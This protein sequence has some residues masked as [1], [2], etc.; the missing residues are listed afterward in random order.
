MEIAMKRHIPKPKHEYNNKSTSQKNDVISRVH[1]D[2]SPNANISVDSL[3]PAKIVRLQRTLG[4]QFML[5]LISRTQQSPL[6]RASLKPIISSTSR[7]K[8]QKR[9]NNIFPKFTK[10]A[11]QNRKTIQRKYDDLPIEGMQEILGEK[12][13]GQF[14]RYNSTGKWSDLAGE[15]LETQ[16]EKDEKFLK[17]YFSQIYERFTDDEGV[18]QRLMEFMKGIEGHQSQIVEQRRILLEKKQQQVEDARETGTIVFQEGLRLV[19]PIH[20]GQVL[21]DKE[22]IPVQ[23]NETLYHLYAGQKFLNTG[24]SSKLFKSAPSKKGNIEIYVSPVQDEALDHK[25]A[26]VG[27]AHH[28]FI[29]GAHHGQQLTAELIPKGSPFKENWSALTYQNNPKDLYDRYSGGWDAH[30]DKLFYSAISPLFEYK[31]RYFENPNEFIM[32][33][34]RQLTGRENLILTEEQYETVARKLATRVQ[35]ANPKGYDDLINEL[36]AS[37]TN[38][39]HAQALGKILLESFPG[40]MM[41]NVGLGPTESMGFFTHDYNV[42]L[43]DPTKNPTP[44][45]LLDTLAF[46][47]NNA[48]RRDELLAGEEDT[49][50]I[51][52]GTQMGYLDM[53]METTATSSIDTLV[54]ALGIDEKY[55]IPSDPVKSISQKDLT[56]EMPSKK[57]LTGQNRRT[58]L[59]YWKMKEWT[60]GQQLEYNRISAHAEG[61]EATGAT[62]GEDSGSKKAVEV[63][64]KIDKSGQAQP[65]LRPL[66]IRM[67]KAYPNAQQYH[68]DGLLPRHFGEFLM[69]GKITKWEGKIAVESSGPQQDI[70]NHLW[71]DFDKVYPS[72]LE[73][74]YERLT[75]TDLG[76]FILTGQIQAMEDQFLLAEYRH[77]RDRM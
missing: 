24:Y 19:E 66:V 46:E 50:D 77:N 51:E 53:L 26:I 5:N 55:L 62:Y 41:P 67:T 1:A 33:S 64:D 11:G 28:R 76:E 6:Q 58:A 45:E 48:L 7:L 71:K 73:A 2:L 59:A 31:D 18:N 14:E 35:A 61:M 74:H 69:T 3:T 30:A 39:E 47:S 37:A 40:G 9:Y 49:A 36:V 27:D 42:I 68:F 22:F 8:P 60:T 70:W 44:D 43:L 54:A 32:S 13:Y 57:E 38:K 56:P 34:L 65:S 17:F 25:I 16:L 29:W 52:F 23:I 20:E 63:S 12:L 4:N 21:A 10:N 75:Y 72:A 15:P